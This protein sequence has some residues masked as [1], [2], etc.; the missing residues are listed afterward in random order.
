METFVFIIMLIVFNFDRLFMAP[1]ETPGDFWEL[2]I[3][4]MIFN[5]GL[6]FLYIR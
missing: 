5:G 2:I 6:I 3:I 1:I 4:S